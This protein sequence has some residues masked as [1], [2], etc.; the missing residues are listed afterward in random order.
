MTIQ[1]GFWRIFSLLLVAALV[2][3]ALLLSLKFPSAEPGIA[4]ILLIFSGIFVVIT[5]A[6]LHLTLKV[7]VDSEGLRQ[8]LLPGAETYLAWE[9]IHSVQNRLLAYVVRGASPRELIIVPTRVLRVAKSDGEK[10]SPPTSVS[11]EVQSLLER[12]L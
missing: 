10:F 9:R 11:R 7:R 12:I 3:V 6:L 1:V 4:R 5:A 8:V 2:F